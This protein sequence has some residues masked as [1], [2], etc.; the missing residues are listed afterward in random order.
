MQ[1]LWKQEFSLKVNDIQQLTFYFVTCLYNTFPKHIETLYFA[2]SLDSN[3]GHCNIRPRDS[4][5]CC[6]LPNFAK[7]YVHKEQGFWVP[8][9]EEG[10]LTCYRMKKENHSIFSSGKTETPFFS[11]E[12]L[13]LWLQ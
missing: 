3:G 12:N 2:F 8:E 13:S 11:E 4:L 6:L 1:V 7:Q 5:Y 10:R 9:S